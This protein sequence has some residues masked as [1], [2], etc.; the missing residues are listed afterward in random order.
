MYTVIWIL[1]RIYTFAMKSLLYVLNRSKNVGKHKTFCNNTSILN[2]IVLA[3]HIGVHC[4][5][6]NM[7]IYKILNSLEMTIT[8]LLN[9]LN[10]NNDFLNLILIL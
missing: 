1:K 9:L 6:A 5:K 7:I 4:T 3:Q 2:Y 8:T 10:R